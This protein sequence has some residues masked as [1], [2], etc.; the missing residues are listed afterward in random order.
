MS[1]VNYTISLNLLNVIFH[2][3]SPIGYRTQ[4]LNEI[5]IKRLG[6]L[7]SREWGFNVRDTLNTFTQFLPDRC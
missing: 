6:I 5:P 1:R 3:L 7:I 2:I 4:V